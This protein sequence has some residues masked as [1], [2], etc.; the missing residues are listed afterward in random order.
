MTEIYTAPYAKLAPPPQNTAPA[1]KT[2][3]RRERRQRRGRSHFVSLAPRTLGLEMMELKLTSDRLHI[4]RGGAIA[5]IIAAINIY[6]AV[7]P[8]AHTVKMDMIRL[9][10]AI[11]EKFGDNQTLVEELRKLYSLRAF[12]DQ[13]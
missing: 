9:D 1:I 3:R 8:N 7:T 12:F 6:Q 11:V 4:W 5:A 10:M 13:H 2:K